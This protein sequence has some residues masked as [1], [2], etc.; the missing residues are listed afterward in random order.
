MKFL[1]ICL[2][3]ASVMSKGLPTH[4]ELKEALIHSVLSGNGGFDLHMWATV[5]DRDGVV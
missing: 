3:L 2:L 1:V 5:V 4:A